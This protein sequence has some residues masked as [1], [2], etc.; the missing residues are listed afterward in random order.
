MGAQ[1]I[2]KQISNYTVLKVLRKKQI[3]LLEKG[4]DKNFLKKFETK[5]SWTLEK[6]FRL[7]STGWGGGRSSRESGRKGSRQREQQCKA[8]RRERI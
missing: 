5:S 6:A 8:P 4:K 1:A 2:N 3:R 7:S